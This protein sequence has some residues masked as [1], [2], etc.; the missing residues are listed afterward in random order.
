M[1]VDGGFAAA[2]CRSKPRRWFVFYPFDRDE[3]F[4]MARFEK[5]VSR[6]K[7]CNCS[8]IEMGV[9]GFDGS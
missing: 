1:V 5:G 7:R 6:L 3:F 4:K 9:I 2:S 8:K